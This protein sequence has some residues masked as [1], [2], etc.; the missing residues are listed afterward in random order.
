M[1]RSETINSIFS[2]SLQ[3]KLQ[4]ICNKTPSLE[5]FLNTLNRKKGDSSPGITGLSYKL[6]Q[7]MDANTQKQIYDQLSICW[8]A[9]HIPL[10]WFDR[11]LVPLPKPQDTEI[12]QLAK[13][14]PITLVEVLR[15]L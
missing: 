13:L 5:L 7:T 8:S 9:K 4:V 14:R 15:K 12:I 10:W 2:G 11:L 3:D 1:P 6:L